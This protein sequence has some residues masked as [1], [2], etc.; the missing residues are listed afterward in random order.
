VFEDLQKGRFRYSVQL[1]LNVTNSRDEPV[2]LRIEFVVAWIRTGFPTT[3][4]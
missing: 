1:L 4:L 2:L 3:G